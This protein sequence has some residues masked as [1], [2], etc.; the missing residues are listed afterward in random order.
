MKLSFA[1]AKF[2]MAL[3]ELEKQAFTAG[4]KD[5]VIIGLQWP[6]KPLKLNLYALSAKG[7]QRK[8][9]AIVL[10][11]LKIGARLTSTTLPMSLSLLIE[12][13]QRLLEKGP[14]DS[15]SMRDNFTG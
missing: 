3:A 8:Q 7:S 10:R 12:T 6:S 15:S 2:T 14:R 11:Q 9:S 4:S 5:K 13:W 1:R